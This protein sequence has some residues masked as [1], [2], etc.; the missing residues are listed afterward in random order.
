MLRTVAVTMALR[1]ARICM[2]TGPGVA[3]VVE[4]LALVRHFSGKVYAIRHPVVRKANGI[5]C[6]R[7]LLHACPEHKTAG[8]P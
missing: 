7:E 8:P 4:S 6:W 2:P 3:R 1:A 5:S